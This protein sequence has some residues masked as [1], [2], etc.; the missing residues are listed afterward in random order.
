MNV[1]DNL[2]YTASHEWVRTEADGTVTIGIT[3]FAQDALGDLVFIELPD[4][5]R[6]LAAGESCAVVESVKAASDVYAPLAGEVVAVNESL[7][8]APEALNAD[9]RAIA[10]RNQVFRSFIGQGYYGTH[11][12][13]VILRNI[14]ENPAWYTAY[15]PYQAEISQGRMEALINFQTMVRRPHRHG[16]R[17]R[18]A[19]RRGHRRGRGDDAG[20]AL[21]ASR[22]PTC[23]SCP[24]T[25]TRR[26][27]KW[28]ARAPSRWASTGG[29]RRRATPPAR[30]LRRAAAVPNTFGRVDDHR[31]AGRRG[32]RARRLVAVATDLL[33]LTLLKAP[34]E[35]GADIVVGNTQRFGVPFGF[36]GPHAAFMACRD[37]FKRSMPGPP[38]R[39]VGRR[40]R[41]AR[42][43]PDPADPRAA[44]PP[45]EGHS[46]ICT[47]QVLLAVMAEH[48]RGLPRPRRPDR[49]SPARAPPG[50]DPRRGLR[51]AG[52]PSAATSS[53]PCTSPA[54]TPRAA[55]RAAGRRHQ[56]ARDRR[57]TASASASTRPPPA[58]TSPRW[59]PVRRGASTSIA[60]D[61]QAARRA[62]RALRAQSAFLQH[63]VF[64]THHSEHEMLRYLRALADKDLALDR[65]MIPLGSCT[66]KL[67]ATAE[68]IP[69]TWPEFANIHPLAPAWSRPGLSPADR[70]S[71]RCWSSAPATTR[72][73]CSP[74][75]ARRA[76]TPACWRS[77]PTTA[78]AARA[79]ATSA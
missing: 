61:A 59:R 76:S 47:A 23:S 9:A 30:T 34:G 44:H 4:V 36:G 48:V 15:T 69:V 55:P 3:D 17:Q 35:W 73:A 46:N 5:G 66:M 58:P 78:H 40:R 45:R 31:R 19:A 8:D 6:T 14:L 62:A 52:V 41:Q 42:L 56:P 28:C 1:P 18:L 49:A 11:T 39:R 51:G 26:R 33:A 74:T 71:R 32:A 63:P 77:A 65:T 21:V 79:T 70:R 13:N 16:D 38:D 2:K 54:S 10:D 24:P 12:P 53:T 75:R 64:N 25:C 7:K 43:P 50:R 72:S 57:P 67:N 22:S 68:M 37:A 60:L 27:S 20:Q 29:R